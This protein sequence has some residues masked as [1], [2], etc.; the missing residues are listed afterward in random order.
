MKYLE[1][2][3]S[4]L[5]TASVASTVI[6]LLLLLIRKLF[7]KNLKP[8]VVHI[9]WFLV[10][11]K[12]LVPI[13]PQS[14]ISLFNVL[15]QTLPMEWNSVQKS[16]QPTPFTETGSSTE[17]QS[18]YIDVK[19][20]LPEFTLNRAD[21][22][23]SSVII[24]SSQD[25]FPGITDGLTWL[26]IGSWVWLGGLLCL[27]GYY[28]FS[29]LIFRKRVGNSIKIEDI[30]VLT[31]LEA[32]KQ[33]L[34]IKKRIYAYETSHLRSPCLHGLWRPKIYLPED[35]GTIADSNQL[36]HILMHELIHYKRKDLWINSLWALSVGIHWYNPL[37]WL[38]VRK[39]KADQE[40]ACDASVLETLG[41]R[42]ALSYGMTLLMLSRSFS[43]QPSPQINLS[44]FGDNKYEA[45]R[46]MMMITKFKKGSYRLSA[47]A[48]FLIIVLSAILLTNASDAG[49]ATELDTAAQVANPNL[50]LY[51]IYND[52]FRWF[53]SLD[54]A[55]DFPKYNFKIPDYLPEGY[56]LQSV[57]YYTNFTSS[58]NTNLID[59]ASITFVSNFGQKNEQTIDVKA[60]KG[61]G[62]LLEED[63]LRGA[64]YPQSANKTPEYRQEAVTI[65]NV[66]GTLFTDRRHYK[67]RPET[68]KSFYWQDDNVWY[69]I[70]YYSEHMSQE[71]LTKMVQSFVFP[72]QVQHVRYDGDG[73]SFPL[74][75]ERDLLA[76]KNILGFKVKIPLELPGLK[77]SGSRLLRAGDQNTAY[78]FRQAT[79]ALWTDYGAPHDS[80]IYDVN[81][82]FSLYQSKEPLFDTSKLSLTRMLK[83][84]GVEISAYED[85][86]H[87]YFAPSKEVKLPYYLWKQDDI[88]YTAVFSGMDKY[89]EDNLKAI[90]SAPVQ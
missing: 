45:K 43:Q 40:V 12:L 32:C 41:E 46:R 85:K 74:Y 28:L 19:K 4:L 44:H 89:Q 5:F 31:V 17:I 52:S 72:Q 86:N 61:S 57:L 34:N 1:T 42:E 65:G 47:A 13:A 84:N 27:G 76:A 56:Q 64:P 11:I 78:A 55:L 68:G 67:K 90:I 21:E 18:N 3:F 70:D 10:L 62:N 6:L 87:V 82:N 88:Y 77:L 24:R 60:S 37:V 53:H 33:R 58:N 20:Q 25:H 15:P 39:M 8:R 36:T 80:S 59:V 75:D 22:P 73:N 29:A 69:A 35:I 30:E 16:K 9:L 38:S 26:S 81:D 83:I 23:G 79:D 63:Q 66:E 50:D 2:V 51:P 48:I 14:P 7:Q 49:K 71:E 54:R